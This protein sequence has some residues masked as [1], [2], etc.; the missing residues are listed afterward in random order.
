MFQSI[1]KSSRK[2]MK[3]ENQCATLVMPHL[4]TLNRHTMPNRSHRRD[5]HGE[6]GR[7]ECLFDLQCQRL[8]KIMRHLQTVP[9]NW[10]LPL[11]TFDKLKHF[12]GPKRQ[13]KAVIFLGRTNMQK[14]N[15]E[16]MYSDGFFLLFAWFCCG[17][18]FADAQIQK[19]FN[20]IRLS[21]K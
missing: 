9:Q 12:S 7:I 16:Q 21:V 8:A 18:A 3:I 5:P 20:Y 1:W 2:K 14:N 6:E 19:R 15:W 10:Y 4:H 13:T 17:A 11:S